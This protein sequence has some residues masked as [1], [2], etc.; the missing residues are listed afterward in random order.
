MCKAS[1]FYMLLQISLLFALCTLHFELNAQYFSLGTD[2]ASVKW[3]QIKTGHFKVIYPNT[4]DSQAL[5]LANALEYFHEPG[6]ASLNVLPNK[7]PVILHNQSVIS[8]A[9]TPY[10]PKR[11]EMVTTPPQSNEDTYGQ[12]WLDQLVIHEFRHACQYA[13]VNKGLTKA[14]S[15]LFGQQAVAGVLGV[16]VP[17][18]FIEGDAVVTETANSNT[19]RG[20]VPAYEMKLRAQF[21]EKGIYSYDKAYNGS[22]RDFTPNWYELGYLLVGQTRVEYGK[23]TWSKAVRKAG[24]LPVMLVPFSYK[25]YKET[26]Y[27]KSRLY[28]HITDE[29]KS[30][31]KTEDKKLDKTTFT[32]VQIS[33]GKFYT[34]RTQPS[35]LPDGSIIVR[36]TSMD[37]IPRIT[38]IDTAG[39]EHIL[40]SPGIMVDENVSAM[41]NMVCW[42]E[43]EYDPRW[44]LRTYSVIMIHDLATSQTRQITQRSRYFSPHM[45]RDLSKIVVVEVTEDSRYFIVIIDPQNGG[46]MKRIPTPGNYFPDHPAW[47]PD[48]KQIA[49]VLTRKE[50]KCLAVAD[51]ESGEFRVVLP[52]SYHEIQKPCYYSEFILLTGSFSGIDNIFAFELPT[53]KLYQ[54]TSSRFGATDATVSPDGKKIYYSNYTSNGYDIV[55][56]NPEPGTWN[57]WNPENNQKFELADQL[58]AQESFIFNAKDVPDSAYTTKPYFKGLNLF[59]P[60]SWGAVVIDADNTEAYP[61][62]NIMS[63][64]LLGTSFTTLGYKYDLN[65]ETGT[66]FLKYSYTGLYPALDLDMDYGRR[67]GSLNDSTHGQLTYKY[68]E[69]NAGGWIRVP[70]NWTVRSWYIGMQPYAGYSHKLLDMDK[71]QEVKFRKDRFNSFN[72]RFYFYAQSRMS[73]RDL[74]PRWAQV[75]DVNYR[76]TLF[77]SDTSSSL[78]A[79]E[80]DLYFPGLVRHHSLRLYGGYQHRIYKYYSY[81]DQIIMPRGYSGIYAGRIFTGSV[82]YEFP[83]FCPDWH[84]GPVLYLKRLKAGIFYDHA[85]TFNKDSNEDYNSLGL[86]LT[87]DFHLFRLFAPFEAGLRTIYFPQTQKVGFE[88]LYSLN[89][90]Y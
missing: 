16:F 14:L 73:E 84:I 7:W 55:S 22:Y 31:W 48:E 34:N 37:D 70:L 89:L 1:H 6:S 18:W 46:V 2:P 35:V 25:L 49:V 43:V 86:D 57:E 53:G 23:E 56:V 9:Y 32:P 36:K 61:G 71:G 50:G 38:R 8:N 54:V 72:S 12:D 20:R 10:A 11:I 76:Q 40:I 66:Y 4:L 58:A 27:G 5:Y 29:T 59:N 82:N 88:F 74:H 42:A 21:L 52:F 44:D 39:Q 64:N 28:N 85:I 63:Q 30:R 65:E 68:H 15:I 26:G 51:A 41:G 62:L 45:S 90:S 67:T 69:F 75:F 17:F 80:V 24:N 79:A 77:E 60:H 19:G 33:P 81:S 13:A 83:V 78:F 87:F 47:S 3:N